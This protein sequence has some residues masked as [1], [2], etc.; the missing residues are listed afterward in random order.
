MPVHITNGISKLGDRIPAV[1]LPP[2]QTCR[3]DAP[4]KK[5]CYATHGRFV[6]RNVK[7]CLQRNLDLWNADPDRFFTEIDLYLKD[8]PYRFFRWFSSGDIPDED[9]LRR[10]CR[11]A[12]THRETSFLCF[13]KKYELV[14]NYIAEKHIIPSNLRIV[15]SRWGDFPCPNPDNFP[16]SWV[17][18]KSDETPSNIPTHA[19]E[20]SGHCGDCVRTDASCWKLKKGE[21]VWFHQH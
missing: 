19:R 17:K 2:I 6:F 4:C 21:A 16:E 13:T 3:E 12:R 14:N 1:N 20:C 5:L 18:F 9:F 7:D 15:F 11:L 10:M 8:I